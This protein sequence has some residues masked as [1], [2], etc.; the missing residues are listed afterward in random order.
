ML[1]LIW[2]GAA[3]LPKRATAAISALT[4]EPIAK[5]RRERSGESPLIRQS[6]RAQM[7]QAVISTEVAT[8][9]SKYSKFMF[10]TRNMFQ[11]YKNFLK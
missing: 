10:I 4:M 5:S 6:W 1:W 11:I 9:E 7:R 8:I 2:A 3:M